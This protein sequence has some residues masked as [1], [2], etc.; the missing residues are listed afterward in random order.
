MTEPVALITGAGRRIGAEIAR[1]LHD[2]G[3]RVVLHYRASESEITQ[4]MQTLNSQR[5]DSA[6]CLHADLDQT[7]QVTRLARLALTHWGRMDL[8][9]NNASS[10]YPTPLGATQESQWDQLMASN[11]KA[12]FFLAQALTDALT[13]SRGCIINIAD[14][15]GERPLA[16]HSVYSIAKAG[17]RMLTKSLALELAPDVRVNGIAPGAMLW[18]EADDGREVVNPAALEKI[19]LQRLGGAENIARA[20]TFLAKADSYITGHILTVDGGRSLRQ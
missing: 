13:E 3:Y 14:I 6:H 2:A 5:K 11:L 19:P 8:L 15:H 20:V 9:V 18:P 7:S 1:S 10:F 17:N 4:L 16:N 12:P